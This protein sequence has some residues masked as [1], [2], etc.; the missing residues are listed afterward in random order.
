VQNVACPH[1]AGLL[2]ASREQTAMSWCGDSWKTS[3]DFLQHR[4]KHGW[5]LGPRALSAYC[6]QLCL[7]ACTFLNTPTN[8]VE[9]APVLPVLE[10]KGQEK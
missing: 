2:L 10:Q 5:G 1:K 9:I 4:S 6:T 3:P 8:A 7:H